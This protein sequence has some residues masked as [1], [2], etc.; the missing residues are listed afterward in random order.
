MR[1]GRRWSRA[2]GWL[3][4]IVYLGFF[5]VRRRFLGVWDITRAWLQKLL[6]LVTAAAVHY[7]FDT[8]EFLG[9]GGF[10]SRCHSTKEEAYGN[11]RFLSIIEN[12][13]VD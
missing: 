8:R 7:F 9:D 3:V 4:S 13:S 10:D 11:F 12:R 6:V 5:F 2:G 1:L